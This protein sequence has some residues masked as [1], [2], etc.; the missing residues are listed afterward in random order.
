VLH[1]RVSEQNSL[2][3]PGPLREEARQL[4]VQIETQLDPARYRAAWESGQRRQLAEV[5]KQ[6]LD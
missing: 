2:N 1:H 6:I 4:Q 3:R 5:V